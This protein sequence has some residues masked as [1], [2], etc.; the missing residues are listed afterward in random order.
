[1]VGTGETA[2]VWVGAAIMVK[3]AGANP[4]SGETRGVVQL[5]MI[6][7]V[8]SKHPAKPSAPRITHRFRYR[9]ILFI[10]SFFVWSLQ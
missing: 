7:V 10:D 3:S 1:M 4:T 2:G 5:I 9:K 6:S 8:M